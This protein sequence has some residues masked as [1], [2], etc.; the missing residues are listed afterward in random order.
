MSECQLFFLVGNN[1]CSSED[2]LTIEYTEHGLN[3]G[4][5]FIYTCYTEGKCSLHYT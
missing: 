1:F 4:L 2:S 3:G 5:N